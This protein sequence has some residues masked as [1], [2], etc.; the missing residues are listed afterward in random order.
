MKMKKSNFPALALTLLIVTGV[1][2]GGIWHF[3][4][5]SANS[6]S[7]QP[8]SSQ[9]GTGKTN[10]KISTQLTLLGDTF[11][12]YST[13]RN[14][15][16]Q[17]ALA[18]VGIGLRYVDEFDQAKRAAS[19]SQGKA[20]L[21]VTTLDQFLQQ[22]P[23][24]KIVGMIDRTIGADAVVL[25]TQKYP[26]LKSMQD[27][28]QLIQQ[29]RDQ[30]QTLSIAF[31]GDTPSEYLALILDIRFEGF[32][33]ADFEQIRV[34]D[35][36]DAWKLMNDPDQNVAIAVLWEPYVTQAR[37]QGDTIVLSSNDAQDS[38][39]DVIVASDQLLQS[40]PKEISQFLE[41]YYRRIDTNVQD[42][43]QLK[44]QIAEDG[45]LS[46]E[47]AE[48]VLQGIDFFT[49]AE[50]QSWMV[51]NT[52]TRRIEA[53][54]S[55]LVRS[56]RLNTIPQNPAKLF[57]NQF[58]TTAALNTQILIDQVRVDNPD[59]AQRLAGS[60]GQTVAA[61]PQITAREVQAAPDI[62]NLEVQGNVEFAIGS[63][64]LTAIGQQTLEGL[65]K[66]IQEFNP[67]TVA[68]RVIGH[69]SRT[70]T[71]ALN[72]TIS[73]Q[74]AQVVVDYLLGKGVKHNIIAEGKGFSEPLPD[75]S[76]TD[77][78]NQR[79]QIRLVRVDSVSQS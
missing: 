14:S 52:L 50:A 44:A 56:N 24:G 62:G 74:R 27:L 9:S 60:G 26:N 40:K 5:T 76:P 69:T 66:E 61:I 54:S 1:I 15:D 17:A 38:I 73:Q 6:I 67:Q 36:S 28:G 18:E 34:A 59:L 77:V 16:F 72:Q 65:V 70:G 22:Q 33:L 79:T 64:Q 30:G 58:L 78:R 13:F 75:I 10:P 29:V 8:N 55:V 32:A 39:I 48:A 31:A 20:D 19:L 23:Q 37:Q 25:N 53:I 45:G 57:N 7:G 35:A 68:V 63:A 42:A 41:V 4:K 43:S 51:D 21:F 46:P 12:G 3:R 49:A 2:G 47:D 11:S 71:A